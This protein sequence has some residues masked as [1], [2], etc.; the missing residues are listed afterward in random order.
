MAWRIDEHVV[1]GEIDNRVR[2]SVTGRIWFAG[3]AEA[4]ELAL[5]GNAWADLAGRK[6]EFVNPSPQPGLPGSFAQK[7]EGSTGDITASRKVRVPDIPLGEF[8]EYYAAKK[9]FPWHWGN[10][11]YLEWYSRSNGRVVIETV[12]F[13]LRIVGEPAWEMTAEEEKEQRIESARA[14]TEFMDRL[15]EA[16]EDE[17]S[18]EFVDDLPED[19]GEKPPTEEEAEEMQARSDLLIDRVQARLA[20]E[21][22]NADYAQILQE[23]IDRLRR[24][25]GEPGPTP[26]HSARHAAW[27]DAANQAAEE[28]LDD[29]FL[30]E[31]ADRTHPLAE[32]AYELSV[33]LMQA[34][35][36]NNWVP[37][38]ASE[39]HPAADLVGAVAKASAKLAGALNGNEWPPETIFCASVIVRLKRARV[40]L[41]DALRATESCQEQ[42]LIK[43]TLLG[44]IL[45]EIIDLAHEADELIAELRERL[46]RKPD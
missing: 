25:R 40:Y 26:E 46:E 23:E 33:Q 13:E 29:P 41:D 27:I 39:E 1:R 8:D 30:R 9:P 6:L 44:P 35:D 21:G 2:G 16:A 17:A 15:V 14:M 43:P 5:K 37:D 34:E 28:A 32:K 19:W 18:A 11:L 22:D 42:K 7:Q 20:R 36:E 3:R 45:V 38:N 10:S 24:E 12:A 31:E 4:V